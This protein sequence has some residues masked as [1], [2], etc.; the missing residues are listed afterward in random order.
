MVLPFVAAP[1]AAAVGVRANAGG[2]QVISVGDTAIVDGSRSYTLSGNNLTY[3]W[4]FN[5]S[6]GIQEDATGVLA[7]HQYNDTGIYTVTLT[8]SDGAQ[9]DTDTTQVVVT[10]TN[11]TI[12]GVPNL[13]PVARPRNIDVKLGPEGC[14]R[15]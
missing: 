3:K 8:A 1:A 7:S 5:Q 9:S 2:S 10:A 12:P 6:D 13:P 4:D 11:G 14:G 15:A